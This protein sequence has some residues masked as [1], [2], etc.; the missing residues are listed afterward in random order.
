MFREM[1][2]KN[3]ALTQEVGRIHE[4]TAEDDLRKALMRLARKYAPMRT[5]EQHRQAVHVENVCVLRL[6]I[7]HMSGKQA[8][9]LAKD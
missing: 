8:I 1:R 7:E 6:D 3:Q 5:E 2:R 9:E 4:V